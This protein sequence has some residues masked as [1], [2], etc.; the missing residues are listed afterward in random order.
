[1]W[2]WRL[3]VAASPIPETFNR[4]DWPRLVARKTAD[5]SARLAV[6]ESA[7]AGAASLSLDLDGGTVTG[8]SGSSFDFDGGGA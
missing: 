5:L 2:K 8:V 6:V 3:A 1:M 4:Q 7:P